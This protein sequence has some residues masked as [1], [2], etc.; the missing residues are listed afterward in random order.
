M[1]ATLQP[2]PK[3]SSWAEAYTAEQIKLVDIELAKLKE[4]LEAAS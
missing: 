3:L 1:R 4:L 2:L